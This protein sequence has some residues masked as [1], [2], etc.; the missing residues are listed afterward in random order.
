MAR[1]LSQLSLLRVVVAAACLLPALAFAQLNSTGVIFAF[2]PQQFGP[3]QQFVLVPVPTDQVRGDVPVQ[4]AVPAAFALLRQGKAATYGNSSLR[5]TDADIRQKQ[6]AV[7]IDPSRAEFFLIIAAETVYTFTQLGIEKVVFPGIRDQGMTRADIPYAAYRLQV[8]MWQALPPARAA[9]ADVLLPDRTTLDAATFYTRL[10]DGDAKVRTALFDYLGGSDPLSI[11]AALGAIQTLSVPGFEARTAPL[12]RSAD[13]VVREAAL[14]ALATS[15]VA[16]GWDPIVA[17]TTAETTPEL[18]ALAAQLLAQSPLPAYRV[19]EVF[20]RSRSGAAEAR[21]VAI[22][23]LGDLRDDRV[24]PELVSYLEDADVRVADASVASLHKLQAWPQLVTAMGNARLSD[25]VRLAAASALAS[26][27]PAN[28]RASALEFRGFK[29]VGSPAVATL[30]AIAGLAGTDSRATVEKFLAH[31]TAEVRIR[32]AQI[33]AEKKSTASLSTL[34]AAERANADNPTVRNAID[35]AIYAI[36]VSQSPSD[37][38]R[39]AT[40]SDPLLKRAA[41]RALGALVAAGRGNERTLDLLRN[42]LTD[43]AAGIRGASARA[44]AATRTPDALGLVL[45]LQADAEASVLADL[46]LALGSFSE[47][48]LVEQSTP[49]LV[50]FTQSGEPE[51]VSGALDSIGRLGLAR[52]LPVVLEKVGHADP[53]VRASAISA[54]ASLADNAT[55]GRV[56]NAIIGRLRDPELPNRVLA[57]QLLGRFN[58]ETSVLGLSQ[59]V[60]EPSPELRFATIAALGQTGNAGA[61]GVLVGLTEE[62][63]REIRLAA[64][65]ALGALGLKAAVA[66][67]TAALGRTTDP[68]TRDALT[69]LISKLGAEGR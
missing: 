63:D 25:A 69:Q 37:I 31:P 11:L 42:G 7:N 65:R 17:A 67:L 53:R 24:A 55:Q 29:V 5:M 58:S 36:V 46:A 50:A 60:R 27:G 12:L 8:P 23:Q 44:L 22:A 4:S 32:A 16:A 33:L 39:S 34:T 64:I 66:P 61:M 28:A 14:R 15:R 43:R 56:L 9:Y 40:G 19:H 6:V 13:A 49:V 51:V 21:L 47:P 48:A 54:A 68:A 41:Y 26:D 18:R 35:D 38:N 10:A 52:L 45:G 57:A 20:F 2:T 1:I 62:P 30:E 59:V 3:A